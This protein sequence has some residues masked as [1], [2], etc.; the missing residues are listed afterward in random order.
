MVFAFTGQTP[1]WR[2]GADRELAA[3]DPGYRLSVE[4][5]LMRFEHRYADLRQLLSGVTLEFIRVGCTPS[6]SGLAPMALYRGWNDLLLGDRAAAA[7]EGRVVVR[8]AENQKETKWNRIFVRDLLAEGNA[9]QGNRSAAIAAAKEVLTFVPRLTH[10]IDWAYFAA[11]REARVLAWS[12]ARDQ[13]AGLLDELAEATPSD[14]PAKI[15]RDPL[16]SVP[17][18]GNERYEQLTDRLESRIRATIPQ[19]TPILA[20]SGSR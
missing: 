6:I 16:Y 13:A 8:L 18:A 4:F 11:P 15:T 3:V 20:H 19:L 2:A 5:E 12:G 9:L 14:G 7:A 17:L 10:P 1:P